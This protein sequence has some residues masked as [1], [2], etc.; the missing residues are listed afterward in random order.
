MNS[1]PIKALQDFI[2]K[3]LP[4]VLEKSMNKACVC[5]QNEAKRRCP[6][7][8]GDL[9]NSI[10]YD[11]EKKLTLVT[12]KVGTNKKHAPYV[13]EGTGIHS[14]Q[15]NGRQDV[16]WAYKDAKGEWHKTSGMKPTP[17]L[18]E[19]MKSKADE[20]AKCFEKQV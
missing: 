6:K 7:D 3:G 8:T 18:E 11:T 5:I 1:D 13:H 10:Q 4:D 9:K 12:G 16:P 14:R 2:D 19:A 20:V 17:F 15:G